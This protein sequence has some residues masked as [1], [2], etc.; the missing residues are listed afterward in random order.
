MALSICRKKAVSQS[1]FEHGDIVEQ[2]VSVSEE[3]KKENHE[4]MKKLV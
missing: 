1:L 3:E 2:I 4:L